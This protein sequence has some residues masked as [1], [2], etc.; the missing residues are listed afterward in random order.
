MHKRFGCSPGIYLNWPDFFPRGKEWYIT[1]TILW[2]LSNPLLLPTPQRQSALLPEHFFLKGK[3][4]QHHQS[5]RHTP[6]SHI[7]LSICPQYSWK[8]TQPLQA[9][10]NIQLGASARSAPHYHTN[11]TIFSL[12]HYLSARWWK[13]LC[14]IPWGLYLRTHAMSSGL[15]VTNF[16][17]LISALTLMYRTTQGLSLCENLSHLP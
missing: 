7:V 5:C 11:F 8:G 9:S 2:G 1:P 15:A 3:Q 16:W 12:Q 17:H 10:E 14:L 6:F 13:S 4:F